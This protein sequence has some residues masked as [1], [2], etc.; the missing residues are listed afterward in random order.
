MRTHPVFLCL[1]GRTCVAVGGD[2]PIEEK[3]EACRRAGADVTVVAPEVT[4]NLRRLAEAGVVRWVQRE[5]RPGDLRGV[6]LAYAS[7]H[8][9]ERIGRLR[10]EAARER[11]LL[12]VIDEPEA[13]SFLAPAVVVR[14][15]L[16][17]AVGTGGASPAL[18]ARLRREIERHV[19]P[20]YG[21][22]VAI[23]G[24][25]RR[26]RDGDPAR[27]AVLESLLDSPLLELLQRGD[28]PAV[29]RLLAKIA[30][31]RCTLA[32][33]GLEQQG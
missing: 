32:S 4:E 31:E 16:Q 3:V 2:R 25:V 22:L 23:L 8:D 21:P 5:Y 18:A 7:T 29:D 15:D 6:A 28:R 26:T 17:V 11:V 13:C 9:A 27:A 10:E 14:G 19:G 30:G 20:E 1:E 12:N 33:L 24:A